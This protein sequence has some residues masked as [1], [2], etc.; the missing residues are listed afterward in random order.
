MFNADPTT[1]SESLRNDL[2]SLQQAANVMA[3]GAPLSVPATKPSSEGDAT[4]ETDSPDRQYQ[5]SI[6]SD[7]TTLYEHHMANF[8]RMDCNDAYMQHK[9]VLYDLS[10]L[11]SHDSRD[12]LDAPLSRISLRASYWDTKHQQLLDS[13]RR[14]ISVILALSTDRLPKELVLRILAAKAGSMLSELIV[15]N[16]TTLHKAAENL[17]GCEAPN[18]LVQ[19]METTFLE[20]VPIRLIGVTFTRKDTTTT[21][22]DFPHCSISRLQSSS[23]RSLI[24]TI[25]VGCNGQYPAQLFRLTASMASLK[26]Q[27]PNLRLLQIL[28]RLGITVADLLKKKCSAGY[29]APITYG[30]AFERLVTAARST[31][32]GRRQVFALSWKRVEK[33]DNPEAESALSRYKWVDIDTRSATESVEQALE[34]A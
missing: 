10:A 33:S 23:L 1:I 29:T 14:Y 12:R 20:V 24:L 17:L 31:Q 19:L 27:L 9:N 16:K 11:Q 7:K 6:M 3:L 15:D 4:P 13:H 32:V 21:M 34:W 22:V 30:A 28:V 8:R 5:I 25:D 2:A 26:E 18:E